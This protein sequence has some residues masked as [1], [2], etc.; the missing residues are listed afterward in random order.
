[1]LQKPADMYA[2]GTSLLI[3]EDFSRSPNC[4]EHLR[5]KELMEKAVPLCFR[6][7]C[8]IELKRYCI[9]ITRKNAVLS[10]SDL[11]A[12]EISDSLV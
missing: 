1:M 8:V 7:H 6:F 5:N 11:T 10:K 2:H 4:F 12:D 3:I 9:K